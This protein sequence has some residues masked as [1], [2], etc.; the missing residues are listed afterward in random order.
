MPYINQEKIIG[1]HD[2]ST[3]RFLCDECFSK[4]KDIEEKDYEPVLEDK[5]KDEDLYIC[6]G[7]KERFYG[8]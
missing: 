6:D 7:C 4:E 3:N 5:M 1:W 2:E 8:N